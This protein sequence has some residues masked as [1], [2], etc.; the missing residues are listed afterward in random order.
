M[1]HHPSGANGAVLAPPLSPSPRQPDD[2]KASVARAPGS[3]VPAQ[4]AGF[5]LR[6]AFLKPQANAHRTVVS[7]DGFWSF[8]RDPDGIG[9]AASWP[10]G[11]VAEAEL[12]VPASWNEQR[13]EL[14]Q[15]FGRGWYATTFIAPGAWSEAGVYLHVGCAQHNARVWLN[16]RPVGAHRGGSLPFQCE[17]SSSI[18]AGQPNL[19]VIEVDATI[20][21][22]GLPP[23][24]LPGSGL[25]EGFN[26]SNPAVAYDFFPYAGL[27]RSVTLQ[28]TPRRARLQQIT[29]S[30]SIDLAE[31]RAIV[32]VAVAHSAD[33]PAV[34]TMEL[35]GETKS[36]ETG[37]TGDAQLSFQ[38]ENVRLWDVGRPEF[39]RLRI[40]L[41]AGDEVI[42]SYERD[43]G[44]REVKVHDDAL[45]LN[46]RKIFLTGFGKH[47]DFPVVGRGLV[48]AL[49]VKDFDLLRWIGANSFRTSHYPYAEEWY[50]FADR[51][52]VL[53]IGETPFVGLN[54][55][56]YRP[57]V[58]ER[59]LS[60]LE[61][62]IARDRHHPSVIMWSVA[63]EPTVTTPAGHEF[64]RA[65]L[66]RARQLDPS[67]P[68]TLV[69][70]MEPE[71]NL[72]LHHADVVC[73]NK[74][75]GWYE[76]PG[77]LAGSS[78]LLGACL[79]RFRAAFGKPVIFAEFG[80][81]A[82]P[83]LHTLPAE[84]FSEEY[85]AETIAAHYAEARKR[86]WIVGTHAWAFA[87]FKAAQSITRV[88]FNHKGVF[89]RER[90]PKL[91]AHT[92]RRLWRG[93]DGAPPAA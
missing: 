34:V 6:H 39:Y 89:T 14:M 61:E 62:M 13:L 60:I 68:V 48:P 37:D 88:I 91:A 35:D 53:V 36:F 22:W 21:P 81:D 86:P 85:Q 44:L 9:E 55:R 65:L 83:G 72:A 8:R 56:M 29:T 2:E 40:T 87:D 50:E 28:I 64:F 73:V 18:I 1:N 31:K 11:F 49:V 93:E 76:Q 43:L 67:R 15:F 54:D 24:R 45:W 30:T 23:G 69:A 74:Y 7:L 57:D 3:L 78:A 66:D 92:L 51:Q 38:L 19:L 52:G 71:N 77:D 12:A 79:D 59:A 5:G 27:A 46:G 80:A 17:L 90:Q 58:Q 70:H 32:S 16:G 25:Y 63:N 84:M 42:D 47:E 75:F 26:N 33:E 82:I 10:H 20:D 4:E 41:S